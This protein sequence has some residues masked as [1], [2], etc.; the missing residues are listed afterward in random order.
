VQRDDLGDIFGHELV[1]A[2]DAVE[3]RVLRQN[4]VGLAC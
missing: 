4:S 2:L 1:E 3:V